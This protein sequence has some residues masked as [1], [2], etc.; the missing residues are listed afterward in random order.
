VPEK[1]ILDIR[2]LNSYYEQNHITVAFLPTPVCEQFI[3]LNS[4]SLRVLLTGGDKLRNYIKKNYRLYN[5]Y[6][7]TENTVV[8]TRFWVREESGNIPIGKPVFNTRIT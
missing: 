4:P 7:P 8:T 6:G 5:N 2:A 3:A 1:I